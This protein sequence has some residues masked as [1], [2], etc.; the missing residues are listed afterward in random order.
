VDERDGAALVNEL[1][2]PFKD[3]NGAG[4]NMKPVGFGPNGCGGESAFCPAGFRVPGPETERVG[5]RF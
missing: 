4:L 1:A 3:G 2:V 5:V